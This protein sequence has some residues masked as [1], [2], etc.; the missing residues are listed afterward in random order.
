MS[1][2]ITYLCTEP[3]WRPECR[4]IT[5]KIIWK[6]QM[7]KKGGF[8]FPDI[9]FP[10]LCLL[11][12]WN[13]S[14]VNAV[15]PDGGRLWHHSPVL[16]W[17]CSSICLWWRTSAD[18]RFV[19]VSSSSRRKKNFCVQK[20]FVWTEPTLVQTLR[21]RPNLSWARF[22]VQTFLSTFVSGLNTSLK[23]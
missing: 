11:Y 21:I 17:I 8:R 20:R 9:S 18:I 4:E 15:A 7:K 10:P 22:W 13:E 12:V 16:I 1:T 19:L 5:Q 2:R 3:T 6:N 14:N 23:I